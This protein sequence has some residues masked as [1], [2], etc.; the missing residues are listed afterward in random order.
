MSTKT[1]DPQELQR[2][3]TLGEKVEL[4]DVRTPAE[5]REVQQRGLGQIQEVSNDNDD[6]C[7]TGI[8]RPAYV[9]VG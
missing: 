9:I 8:A 1:I 6:G 3:V 4:I 7:I 2:L 5:F